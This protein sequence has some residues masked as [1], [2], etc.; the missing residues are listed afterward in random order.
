VE[1][2]S[3]GY[4]APDAVVPAKVIITATNESKHEERE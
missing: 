3:R 2:L 4:R 1:V